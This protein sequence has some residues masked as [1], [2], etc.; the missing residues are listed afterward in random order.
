MKI[1]SLNNYEFKNDVKPKPE[2]PEIKSSKPKEEFKFPFETNF[3]YD[4]E[5]KTLI[6]K[7]KRGDVLNQFPSD[8]FLRMKKFLLDNLS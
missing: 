1:E 4:E 3:S 5:T 8:D 2:I 7:V 6:T